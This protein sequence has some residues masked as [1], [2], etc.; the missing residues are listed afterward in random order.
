MASRTSSVGSD[1]I[2]RPMENSGGQD[3]SGTKTAIFALLNQ[4]FPL[5]TVT[6]QVYAQKLEHR[7]LSTVPV[8]TPDARE[9]R[10]QKRVDRLKRKRKPKPLSA[11][12]KRELRIYETPKRNLTYAKFNQ[13]TDDTLVSKTSLFLT[14]CGISIYQNSFSVRHMNLLL[15]QM[16][17][18]FLKQIITEH[19]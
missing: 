9:L 5:T 8:A 6:Q 1:P 4:A 15:S 2:F 17:L 13:V 7:P 19:L 10:R 12:E 3:S 11:K 14:K 16:D 18:S